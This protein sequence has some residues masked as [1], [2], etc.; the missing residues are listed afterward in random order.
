MSGN[1]AHVSM[2]RDRISI[3]GCT[4][5]TWCTHRPS[6]SRY[7][8][9]Y[10]CDGGKVSVIRIALINDEHIV[11]YLFIVDDDDVLF[12]RLGAGLVDDFSQSILFAGHSV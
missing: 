7:T 6:S 8:I 11:T 4:I 5:N 10:M 2:G 3:H 9:R 12:R 1:N